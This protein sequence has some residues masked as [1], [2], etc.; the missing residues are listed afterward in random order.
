MKDDCSP[1]CTTID[2]RK[3]RETKKQTEKL[4]LI[5]K[6][7]NRRYI[8]TTAD[9]SIEDKGLART[10]RVSKR[11]SKTTVV[12]NPWTETIKNMSDMPNEAYQQMVCVE[13]ANAFNDTIVLK[14]GETHELSTVISL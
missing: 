12:W 8:N 3:R 1:V 9:C 10:I 14:S 6:E 4:L 11:G 5:G 2:A 7:E 13:A